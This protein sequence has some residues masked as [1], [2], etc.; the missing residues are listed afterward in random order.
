M[1]KNTRW[2][3]HVKQQQMLLTSNTSILSILPEIW[4][5]GIGSCHNEIDYRQPQWAN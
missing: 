2:M 5:F 1:K 4:R 3:L